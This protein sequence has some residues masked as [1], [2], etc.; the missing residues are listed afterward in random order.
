MSKY[1]SWLA[2][3]I[4]ILKNLVFTFLLCFWR[5]KYS[6][7]RGSWIFIHGIFIHL[8]NQ[9]IYLLI[10][11]TWQVRRREEDT[12]CSKMTLRFREDKI[13]SLESI[14]D[15]LLSADAYLLEEKNAL[16]EELQLIRGR[17]D[18]N[19]ELTRFAMENIR[20]LEQL[21]R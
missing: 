15:G 14:E 10:A 19:P 9:G 2:F 1:F 12:Q 8:W 3:Y 13:R 21:R 7:L 4:W 16:S 5:K 17:L 6:T 18:R 20:L 11:Y